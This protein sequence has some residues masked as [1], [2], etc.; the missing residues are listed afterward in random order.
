VRAMA[1][2]RICSFGLAGLR[3]GIDIDRVREVLAAPEVTPVPLAAPA[4]TGL[5]NLRGQ[6]LTVVD[7]R[8]RL[9]LPPRERGSSTHVIVEHAGEM[10]SVVVDSDDEVIDVD[11]EDLE[12]VPTTVGEP[13]RRCASGSHQLPTGLLVVLDVDI[14]LANR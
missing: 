3:I 13:I 4:V 10:I 14:L 2:R 5:I 1:D 9:S 11:A 12:P 6:I 7:A 8:A